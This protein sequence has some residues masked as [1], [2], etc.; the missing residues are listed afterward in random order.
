M[1]GSCQR[2]PS[3]SASPASSKTLTETVKEFY[4][5]YAFMQ[6]NQSAPRL[7]RDNHVANE[8]KAMAAGAGCAHAGL[9]ARRVAP[10]RPNKI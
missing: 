1:R 8:R 9:H 2:R 10:I 3:T 4:A 6:E 7:G 5:A